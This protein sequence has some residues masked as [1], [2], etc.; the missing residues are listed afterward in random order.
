MRTAPRI[1]LAALALAATTARAQPEEQEDPSDAPEDE[2]VVSYGTVV[3]GARAPLEQSELPLATDVVE[4]EPLSGGAAGVSVAEHL[5][6]T[7]GVVARN[8]HNFA[9]DLRL[10]VRGF[11]A[12]T[13]FGVRGVAVV[14]DGIPLTMPDGQAQLDVV[15][16]DLLGRVEVLRGPAGALYG[17]A[18]GGVLYLESAGGD[19]R[20]GADVS[21]TAGSFGLRKITARAAEQ[22]GDVSWALGASHLRLEGFRERSAAEQSIASGTL[23]WAL[24][25]GA[26]RLVAAYVDAPRAEDPGGLTAGELRADPRQAAPNNLAYATGE[27]VDQYQLGATWKQPLGQRESLELSAHHVGRDYTGRIPFRVNQL[28]RSVAGGALTLR[29]SRPLRGVPTTLTAAV[30][31]R[32]MED[33]RLTT[34]SEGGVPTGEVEARQT[35]DVLALGGYAQA[36]AMP[37]EWLGLLAGARYDRVRFR[38]EDRHLGDGDQSGS[39]PF[40]ALTGLAGVVVAWS[41]GA[42]VYANVAESFETPT[43]TELA[44]RPEGGAGLNRDLSPQRA[45]SYELG[46]RA[47]HGRASADLATF[48]MD[49]SDELVAFEDETGRTFY[50]NAGASH[51]VGAEAAV[52][53]SLPGRLSLRV[54]YAWLRARF[55]RYEVAGADLA[56]NAV[57]GLVPHRI[58]AAATWDGGQGTFARLETEYLHGTALDDAN[59]ARSESYAAVDA[60]IGHRGTGG[61]LRYELALGLTNLFDALYAD[62]LR[63]NAFGGRYFEPGAPRSLYLRAT[64]GWARD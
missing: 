58:G 62:N 64:V 12:R 45:R 36:H 44:L 52:D 27:S 11:G 19:V 3:L 34:G 20:P 10:S 29:S 17:N 40:D 49:L 61:P 21:L 56:G 14:L 57:P 30:E 59:R 43:T 18:A 4:T 41:P 15:D 6:T 9:Q 1:A 5:S 35:E 47:E 31:G 33:Q 7:P 53:L 38:L 2:E 32:R 42:R 63:V 13:A 24:A 54:A 22:S 51:R 8:R 50:R 16:P 26:L 60:R 48:W 28:D 46:V 55:D 25:G 37:T 39:L 23:D